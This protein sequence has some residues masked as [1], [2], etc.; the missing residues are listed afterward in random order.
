MTPTKL[1]YQ[2]LRDERSRRGWSQEEVAEKVGC[3]T[4][5][6]VARWESGK[7]FPTPYYRRQLAKIYGKSIE[8]LGL[9][10][11]NA[12]HGPGPIREADLPVELPVWQEDWGEAPHLDNFCGREQELAGV[13]QWIRLDHCRVVAVLGIGGVGKTTFATKVAQNVRENFDFVFWR[14]LRDAPSV[15][16]ILES[17]LRFVR[18]QEVINL[19]EALD[20]QISLLISNLRE[21]RC[22]LLLDNVDALLQAGQ[23]AGL[24]RSGYEGYGRLFQ[25]IA[26]TDHQSCLLLTSREKLKEVALAEGKDS[27]PVRSLLLTGLDP[28]S[29][30]KLLQD[31]ALSGSEETWATFINLYSGN[32]LALKVV[33]EPVRQVF[34]GHIAAFLEKNEVVPGDLSDLLE[35]QFRRLSPLE[36]EIMYWLAIEREPVSPGEIQAD[37]VHPLARGTLTDAFDSLL[38]RSMIERRGNHRFTLQPV[39][40]EYVTEQFVEKVYKEIEEETIELLGSHALIKAQASDYIRENQMRFILAPLAERLLGS[41]GES[42]SIEKLQHLLARL[43]VMRKSSYAAG[44]I[45]NLSV[46]LHIDLYDYNFSHLSVRQAYL[47]GIELPGIN[48]AYADLKTSLFTETFTSV[49]CVALSSDGKLLAAGTTTGE[50]LLRQANTLT[51]LFLCPGHGDDIRSVAFSPDSRLLAS[52]SEDQTIRLWNTATGSLFRTLH[53]HTNYVRSVTFNP[54]GNMLASGSEDRAIRLWDYMT[55][56]CIHVLEEHSDIVRSVAFSPDGNMLASGSNDQTIRLWDSKTGRSLDMLSGHTGYIHTV[57]FSPDGNLIVSGSEDRT[58]KLWDSGTS[59]CVRT[60]E[61]HGDRIRT[62]AFS[63]DGMLLASGSD[64]QTIRIWDTASGQCLIAWSAHANRIWA[65]A[66]LPHEKTLIS[67]SEDETVRCW[68]VQSGRC[69]KQ[70][71]GYTSL[72][73]AVAFHPAGQIVAS[74]NEDKT[75]SLWNVKTGQC[76]RT[77]SGHN[78]RVRTV[79]ISPAGNIVASGSEDETIR[80]W[81][82]YTG[83]CLRI[84]QGHT[85]LVRSVAFNADGTLLV[86]GS[87][88]QTIRLWQVSN[89]ECIMTLPGQ[90]GLI[91]AVAFNFDGNLIASGSDDTTIRIWDASSG[92]CLQMLRGHTHRVWSVAFSPNSNSLISSSDDQTIRLWDVDAGKHLHTLRGHTNWVR[93]V[94]I[95]PDGNMLASGSHDQ[96][97]RLWHMQTGECLAVLRGHS[98]CLCS[99]AFSP[100]GKTLVSGSDDGTTKLWNVETGECIQ[101]FRNH[102]PYEQMDITGVKGL[103][104]AQKDALKALGAIERNEKTSK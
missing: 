32:P 33:A 10:A 8:E 19:P 24:Y 65:V 14:S 70:I 38:R 52:G 64:D 74:G 101:T 98:N 102:R 66:F 37:I 71:H 16:Y 81:D 97:I 53:G 85:H 40:M 63:A 59:R 69:L 76:V 5:K 4:K 30:Q 31:K 25:R 47:Q 36:Q 22:L 34:E 11:N 45:L 1:W 77:L 78:N 44:N 15:K 48:F 57:V 61:G 89:G 88:D 103:T 28:A 27:S 9:V 29:G 3:G 21:H 13:V 90:G 2:I 82:T 42:A 43:R 79:A 56:Q 86:S 20:E 60:L 58:I 73:K 39:I 51:P 26:E 62:I 49:L 99:I 18:Q 96:T 91:W 92:Q 100:D 54:A 67:A 80:L 95:S 93:T 55:G 17:C 12:H 94:A 35:Q 68:D 72:I 84:L 41:Y 50:V 75:V 7:F 6:T 83:D 87:F 104:E 23:R 46:F